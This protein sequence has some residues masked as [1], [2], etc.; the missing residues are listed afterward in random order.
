LRAATFAD[1]ARLLI[2]AGA[3][4]NARSQLGNS[5]L[6]LAARMP[7]N[8][9]TVKLLLA[10]GAEV[11]AT[12]GFGA[13]ALMAAVAAEDPQ[14]VR[15]LLDQGANVNARPNMDLDGFLFGGG[16]TPL[17]WAAF[18]GNQELTRLLLA[19][20]ADVNGFTQMGSALS[21]AAW[22]GNADVA[23]ILLDAE[24]EVDQRDLR[25]NYTPLHWAASSEKLD[26]TLVQLLLKR[27][28]DAD[29]EGGQPVD[30]FL[31]VAQTPL[32]LAQ[33]RG[34][35][36]V[37]I[38]L[39]EADARKVESLPEKQTAQP[40]R[41]VVDSGDNAM[42]ADA[43][44]RALPPLQESSIESKAS[45]LRHA[46]R[47]DCVSCHQQFLPLGAISLAQ[48][49]HLAVDEVALSQL[50]TDIEHFAVQAQELNLEATFHP[51]PAIEYGYALF[52]GR[53]NKQAPS[54][55]T[56]SQVHQLT[57]MQ[58]PD[59]HWAWNLPR[60]PIQSSD[61][62]ATALALQAIQSYAPPGRQREID[63]RVRRAKAWLANA[64][65][66]GNEERAYQLL[67]L[68]WADERSGRLKKLAESLI[69]QQR[70]DGGWGQLANLP[71]DAYAT[72]QSLYA[73]QVAG[74]PPGDPAVQKGLGFLL[75]TQFEDG[76]WRVKR[77]AF[78]FQPPME[79]G[80]PY[81][82][83]G[84]ISSAATSWAV[85]ALAMS[86]DPSQTPPPAAVLAKASTPTPTITATAAGNITPPVEFTR[87]IQPLLE[88]SCVACHSG[89]RPKGGFAM[90][91]RASVLKGGNRGEPVIVPGNPD[92]GQLIHLVQDQVEDLEMPPLA[93]RNKYPALTKDE[94]TKLSNWIAQD[95]NWPGTVTLRV[96]EK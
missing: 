28:A 93:K 52:A 20:D 34:E 89:E 51:A 13:T 40:A 4:I 23:R 16:R 68:A 95:A 75:R 19:R 30:N 44:R 63:Q 77:R 17:M 10:R 55:T 85:M 83:D 48:N 49:R 91:D 66:E 73:L 53:L 54:I 94:I 38:A 50:V 64:E 56:D 61:I 86:L 25:A 62:V 69:R 33:K 31:G 59:G 1:K 12:N 58:H 27:G 82:K 21:H 57:V 22:A 3:D 74:L 11:N 14:S 76:T 70:T 92:G 43:V 36:P 79:S 8:S 47:Q 72:G 80:F 45:A 90:I 15:L 60:P 7:G 78:P 29:A 96:P 81:G 71:S 2:T 65:P 18:R 46:S 32:M 41:T 88:R 39:R 6:I 35:T 5:A 24:A 67:G 42:I 84:W 9:G 26:D 37:V 87:D